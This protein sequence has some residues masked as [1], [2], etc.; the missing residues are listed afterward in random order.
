MDEGI[1]L[2]DEMTDLLKSDLVNVLLLIDILQWTFVGIGAALIVGMLIWF[3]I[4][5]NKKTKSL[6]VEP[7]YP[8]VKGESQ[9]KRFVKNLLTVLIEI[10][11]LLAE[12]GAN[13]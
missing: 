8:P 10:F 6:S 11:S 12:Q 9:G 13:K 3:F 7:I 2:N 1:E 4:A 5:R